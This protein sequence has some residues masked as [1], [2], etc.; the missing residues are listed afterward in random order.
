MTFRGKR[1][2]S[3]SMLGGLQMEA[4]NSQKV[5]QGIGNWLD[6]QRKLTVNGKISVQ[7]ELGWGERRTNRYQVL[8]GWS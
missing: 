4:F 3:A 6:G 7:E 8:G 2:D 1:K 5:F